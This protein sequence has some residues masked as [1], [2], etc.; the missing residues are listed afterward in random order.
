MQGPTIAN[1]AIN[2]L[3]YSAKFIPFSRSRNK[4]NKDKNLN[5]GITLK[6]G[7]AELTAK[8]TQGQAHVLNYDVDCI[9]PRYRITLQKRIT[10][11]TC[12][13]GKVYRYSK[14]H[15]SI[16]P[17]REKDRRVPSFGSLL[18]IK[19]QPIPLLKDI[20]Y[21]LLTDSEVLEH[22]SFEEWADCFGYDTDSI[23]ANNIYQ[24]CIQTGLRF[25]QLFTHEEYEQL[26]I[27]FEDY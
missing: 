15:D 26:K 16:F 18:S 2:N 11:K 20:I 14:S 22:G 25:K 7:N 13:N 10:D 8:Y 21:S 27:S 1:Q 24:A 9:S 5:W 4:D 19:S 6:K 17:V 23:K 12:E 3:E